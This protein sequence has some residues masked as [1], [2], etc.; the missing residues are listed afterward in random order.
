MHVANP[1]LLIESGWRGSDSTSASEDLRGSRWPESDFTSPSR[2][3][4]QLRYEETSSGPEEPSLGP[5]Y[6]LQLTL[7]RDETDEPN[8]LARDET[9]ELARKEQN[10][11]E[12]LKSLEEYSA[13]DW[14][15]QGACA[16][17]PEVIK[18][19]ASLLQRLPKEAAPPDLAPAA[20]GT[21][22]MEWV[23]PSGLFWVDLGPDRTAWILTKIDGKR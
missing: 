13:D 22:C 4:S 9:D 1:S 16:I 12:A 19:T 17:S 5:A 2:E 15:M 3:Q 10:A 11:L 21:V 7:T 18:I 8:R 6:A 23:T 14:D 20:D